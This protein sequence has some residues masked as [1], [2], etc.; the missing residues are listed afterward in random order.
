MGLTTLKNA[1]AGRIAKSDVTVAKNYLAGKEIKELERVVSMYL[2]FAELQ[3]T[4]RI[5]MRMADWVQRLDAFL[6]FND[7]EILTS[8][9]SV[10]HEVAKT[11]A[12]AEYEK[13]RVVRDRETFSDFE[14]EVNRIGARSRPHKR[15]P[16]KGVE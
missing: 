2:D 4:R 8:P 10:S 13:F 5:G 3:A 12:E 14:R 15:K 7:Y 11:L 1:P 9:G 6:Q 16:R